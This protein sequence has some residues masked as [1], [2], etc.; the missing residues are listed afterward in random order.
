MKTYDEYQKLLD[1]IQLD[2]ESVRFKNIEANKAK[3]IQGLKQSGE[4]YIDPETGMES[5]NRLAIET[6]LDFGIRMGY[7]LFNQMLH[8]GETKVDDEAE[9]TNNREEHR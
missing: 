7:N 4:C 9:D 2:F 5:F 6:A 1:M 3:F 8:Y